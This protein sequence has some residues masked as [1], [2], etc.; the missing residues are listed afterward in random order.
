MTTTEGVIGAVDIGASKVLVALADEAGHLVPDRLVRFS[1]PH[2]SA[3]LLDMLVAAVTDLDGGLVPLVVA[4]VA[5]GP[6]NSETG[7]LLNLHN[8]EWIEVPLGPLLADRL[9]V[10][11]LLE[12]DATAAALG[13][14]MQGA[15]AGC[16]PV[17]YL[18]V[19]SGVGAGI[20]IGG[21][22]FR[23]AHG[24]AGEIGHLV[25]DPKGPR[26]G[27]GR[28]G[29]VESYAGGISVARR[30]VEL[31][32]APRLSDGTASPRTAQEVF[33]LA[34]RGDK[35][36]TAVVDA[37]GHAISC[38]IAALAAVADPARIVVGGSVALAQP[39]WLLASAAKARELCM[40]ETGAVI[41]VVPASLGATSALAGAALL[42]AARL[43]SVGVT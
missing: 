19:S 18:T 32:P 29:D 37:A 8:R 2:E 3:K 39:D 26:C 6:L 34:R 35:R 16:D 21:K 23:G 33:S 9:R 27:C 20:V 30:A 12:D 11:V 24:L 38:A 42:G 1:T 4:C 7:V 40:A 15:G 14:A 25:I 13:E 5:P 10:P 22:S 28:R 43:S 36:A 31:W 17:A 41:D